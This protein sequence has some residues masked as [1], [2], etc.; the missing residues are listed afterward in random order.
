MGAS[1]LYKL[2]KA[3]AWPQIKA[4]GALSSKAKRCIC[5]HGELAAQGAP[6]LHLAA[7]T[8]FSSVAHHVCTLTR[9]AGRTLHRSLRSRASESRQ[10]WE[11]Q[12]SVLPCSTGAN[13]VASCHLL[14]L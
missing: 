2:I 3:T 14:C 6:I 1:T 12:A 5:L 11:A 7:A 9:R 4:I 10:P 13:S 8:I